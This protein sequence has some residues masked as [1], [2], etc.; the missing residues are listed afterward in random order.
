MSRTIDKR[1]LS[2][3]TIP[4]VFIVTREHPD[5]EPA[6]LYIK[7]SG[8]LNNEL[9]ARGLPIPTI[10]EDL[11]YISVIEC[12]TLEFAKQLE[13]QLERKHKPLYNAYRNNEVIAPEKEIEY[14]ITYKISI[15]DA[16]K[17]KE[18]KDTKE[19]YTPI[20]DFDKYLQG[21]GKNKK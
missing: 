1:D 14:T 3:L 21:L 12:S 6:Y 4:V 15:N 2:K 7:A 10:R 8:N 16:P 20:N 5:L 19:E 17:E 18:K 13:I 11:D 9:C